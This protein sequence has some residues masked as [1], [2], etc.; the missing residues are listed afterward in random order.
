ITG[1]AGSKLDVAATSFGGNAATATKLQTART[2]N[3]TSFDGSANITTAN[4][5]TART[6][7]VGN[8]AKSVDGSANVSWSLAEIGAAAAAHTHAISDVTG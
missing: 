4:W 3:G 5:G 7:T 8:T 2:I 6:V 1:L